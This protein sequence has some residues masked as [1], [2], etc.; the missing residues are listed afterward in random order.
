MKRSQMKTALVALF[1]TL[2][3]GAAYADHASD[4]AIPYRP[5]TRSMCLQRFEAKKAQ[6]AQGGY[7]V[8]FVCLRP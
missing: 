3:L 5:W 8:V 1:G 2:S 4:P 7:G 6:A